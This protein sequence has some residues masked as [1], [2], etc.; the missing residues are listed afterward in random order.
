MLNFIRAGA[1]AGRDAPR[2]AGWSPFLGGQAPAPAYCM[3]LS[4]GG[5]ATLRER[6]RTR[7]PVRPDGSI[8]LTARAWAARAKVA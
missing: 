5:R 7:L 3:S 1:G 2:G 6:L 8:H 4:E